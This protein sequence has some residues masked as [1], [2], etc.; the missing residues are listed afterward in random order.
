MLKKSLLTVCA[1]LAVISVFDAQA[2]GK[3]KNNIDTKKVFVGGSVG[4]S[5]TTVSTPA[6]TSSNSSSFKLAVDLGYELSKK[7]AVGVQVGF[8]TGPAAMGSFDLI[9]TGEL[10]KA[11]VGIAGDNALENTSGFMVSP[12]VRHT[13]VSNKTFDLFVD[14][15]IGYGSLKSTIQANNTT[16]GQ[17]TAIFQA[18]VRPGIAFKVSKEFRLVAR[19]GAAGYQSIA[20]SDYNGNTYTKGSTTSHFGISAGTGTLLFGAEYHF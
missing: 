13:L 19:F 14:G 15:V 5:S 8:L 3:K 2:A 17:K 12:F 11:V 20:N 1:F 18:I 10:M 4:F 6:G 16:S 7:D 9:N